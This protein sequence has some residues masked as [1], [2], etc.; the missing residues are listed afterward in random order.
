ML[1]S[2]SS[3]QA[4]FRSFL[5]LGIDSDG[6]FTFV[7]GSGFASGFEVGLSPTVFIVTLA[8]TN[9]REIAFLPNQLHFLIA[10]FGSEGGR[11]LHSGEGQ[12]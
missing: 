1:E 9:Q 7:R 5:A 11:W 4:A 10:A 3:A 12:T 2:F 8:F 6:L